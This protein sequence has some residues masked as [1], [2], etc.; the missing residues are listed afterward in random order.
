MKLCSKGN[1]SDTATV[2][3]R[4]SEIDWTGLKCVEVWNG[5]LINAPH[6]NVNGWVS[7]RCLSGWKFLPQNCKFPKK[8]MK[9]V[10]IHKLFISHLVNS[11]CVLI[12]GN[13]RSSGWGFCRGTTWW[14][15][16]DVRSR[17][18]RTA[19]FHPRLLRCPWAVVW[20]WVAQHRQV[21]ASSRRHSARSALPVTAHIRR[22]PSAA[23][24][25]SGGPYYE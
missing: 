25:C 23:T 2:Q 16:L 11:S 20:T 18:S 24:Y 5:E 7:S 4:I 10:K 6:C 3:Q 1:I 12:P 14:S 17:D 19:P 21:S 22:S 13:Q 9:C 8:K 15:A